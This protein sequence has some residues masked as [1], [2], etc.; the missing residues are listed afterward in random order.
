MIRFFFAVVAMFFVPF[1]VYAAIA[2]VR[3]RGKLEGSLLENAPI[4]WLAVAGAVLAFGTF[5]SLISIE[6]IEY[7]KGDPAPSLR[8]GAAKPGRSP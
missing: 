2:F 7:E 4:N 8:E 1:F 6:I 3:Q 5:A